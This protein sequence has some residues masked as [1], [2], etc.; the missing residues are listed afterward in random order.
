MDVIQKDSQKLLHEGY[1]YT[2]KN[3]RKS[4][5][6]W[7]CSRSA[8]FCC[9]RAATTDIGIQRLI[10]TVSHTRDPNPDYVAAVRPCGTPVLILV[11]NTPATTEIRAALDNPEVVKHTLCRERA[12]HLPP[13]P[14]SLQDLITGYQWIT[15][16]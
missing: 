3:K 8:L 13:H 1:T 15:T 4:T 14:Q 11:D 5:M 9:K 12:K 7:Q 2:E 6:R 10:H 16:G